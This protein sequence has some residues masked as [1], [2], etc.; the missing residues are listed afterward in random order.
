[1]SERARAARAEEPAAGGDGDIAGFGGFA[2]M[3]GALR[4]ALEQFAAAKAQ[5]GEGGGFSHATEL[6]GDK[7]RMVFGYT[8]RMGP[9]GLAAE[10]FGDV[11]AEKPRADA[12]PQPIVEVF[13][14]GDAV[15][16]VAELPGADPEAIVCRADG[17]RLLIEATGVRRYRK[18]LT[19]PVAVRPDGMRQSYRNGI[20]EVRL[21]RADTA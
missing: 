12:A 14:D 5:Q 11:L 20:L 17:A 13:E 4:G 3:V 1:M 7:A 10:P 6:G 19:L 18:T 2:G 15:I 21:T 16:V 9:E 8:V